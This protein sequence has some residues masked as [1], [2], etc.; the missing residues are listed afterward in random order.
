MKNTWSRGRGARSSRGLGDI[1]EGRDP[2]AP[3]SFLSLQT[4]PET[5]EMPALL[6]M[7]SDVFSLLPRA[8]GKHGFKGCLIFQ[9]K[10]RRLCSQPS[11]LG[12]GASF[13][14]PLLPTVF[15]GC[16]DAPFAGGLDDA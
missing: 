12:T 9:Q 1:S 16:P 10:D 11:L 5:L 4:V 6:S 8:P 7:L 3:G 2:G 13:S 14:S 15:C